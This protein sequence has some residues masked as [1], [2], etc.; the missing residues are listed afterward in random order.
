MSADERYKGHDELLD[1]WP[2]LLARKP[3]ATLVV[4]GDGTDRPRLESRAA[5]LGI[6]HAVTF[7]GRV[8]D[9]EL[10]ALYAQC[11]FLVM[12][13]RDEGFGLVFLEAM[14][15]GKA[16]I[17]ANGAAEEIIRHGVTGLIVQPET[18]H[19]LAT[20]VFTLFDQPAV[21]GR[22]GA[23][24]RDRF[25]STFTDSCFQA[26]FALALDRCTAARNAS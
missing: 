7:A 11:R 12:P 14:R 10:A 17:G 2:S 23:A 9:R 18:T 4:A 21:C 25:L 8:G 19:D 24:G 13:S 5:S 26:R 16:C 20:A 6:S 22:Y 15:A 1:M 3:D